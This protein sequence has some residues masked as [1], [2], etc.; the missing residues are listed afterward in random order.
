M[1]VT[2]VPELTRF[3]GRV[4]GDLVGFLEY[5]R[6]EGVWSL[7]HAFTF[8][9]HR[10]NGYAAR[11]TEAALDAA[12]AAGVRVKPVC[13]FVADYLDQ[14]PTYADL[15]VTTAGGRDADGDDSET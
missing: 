6:S 2:D 11:I 7:D 8:P 13:P 9:A 15:A 3:E 4:D 10:G 5:T 1:I 14:H 12:R